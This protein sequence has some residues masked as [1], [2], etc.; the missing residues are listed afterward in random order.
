MVGVSVGCGPVTACG[1]GG[2]WWVPVTHTHL[3]SPHM[4]SD[5][6]FTTGSSPSLLYNMLEESGKVTSAE[7]EKG[8]KGVSDSM[9]SR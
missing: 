6:N 4:F 3:G 8:E 7:L 9:W 5:L 1:H 2:C